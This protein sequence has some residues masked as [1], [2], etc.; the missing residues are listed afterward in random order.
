MDAAK[1][2]MFYMHACPQLISQCHCHHCLLEYMQTEQLALV[3]H[4]GR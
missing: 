4:A 1:K 2:N 3:L